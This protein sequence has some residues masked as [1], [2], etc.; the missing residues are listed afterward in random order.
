[1]R[2]PGFARR[3]H[4]QSSAAKGIEDV[5]RLAERGRRPQVDRIVSAFNWRSPH[6]IPDRRQLWKENVTTKTE[7][8]FYERFPAPENQA[9]DVATRAP[10]TAAGASRIL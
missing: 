9:V 6:Q 4:Q 5:L 7:I 3:R 8:A 1:M 2:G 10:R